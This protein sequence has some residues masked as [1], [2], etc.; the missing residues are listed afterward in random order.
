LSSYSPFASESEGF[1]SSSPIS[2]TFYCLRIAAGPFGRPRL[3][4]PS[5]PVISSFLFVPD[6][7]EL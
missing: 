5:T 3:G 4:P 1:A 2:S 6:N 7:H